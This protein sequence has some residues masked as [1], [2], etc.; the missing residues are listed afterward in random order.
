LEKKIV[1]LVCKMEKASPLEWINVMQ[2][3]LVYLSWEARVGEPVQFSWMY[4]QERELKNLD[5][6]FATR[7]GLRVVLRRHSR[8][9]RL[10]TS[11]T[12]ISHAPTTWYFSGMYFSL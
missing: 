9:K 10:Q 4:R 3:L 8:V 5:I 1:V 11:Q 12:C 7:Q 2:Y 6:P